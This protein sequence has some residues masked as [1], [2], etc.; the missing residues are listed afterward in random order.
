[1]SDT[2]SSEDQVELWKGKLRHV[3]SIYPK[4]SP[5]MLQIGLGTAVPSTIWKPI[6]QMMVDSNEVRIENVSSKTPSGRQQTYTVYSFAAT[7][8]PATKQDVMRNV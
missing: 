7:A 5:S 8:A 2:M 3:L 1:M 6:L 4:L